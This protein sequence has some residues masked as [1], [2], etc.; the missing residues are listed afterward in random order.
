MCVYLCVHGVVQ[1]VCVCVCMFG[2][3]AC[4]T[5]HIICV[6]AIQMTI[7]HSYL[8]TDH[9]VTTEGKLQHLVAVTYTDI[10]TD[11]RV[12]LTPHGMM[13][14]RVQHIHH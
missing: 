14:A 6:L 8:S 4:V 11:T 10:V 2:V 9:Q 12:T 1:Y 7:K 3:C 13:D 5:I